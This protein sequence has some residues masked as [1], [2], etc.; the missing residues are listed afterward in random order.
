MKRGKLKKL[1]ES[2]GRECMYIK[3]W[4]KPILAL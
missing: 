3:D 4:F 2:R 1:G